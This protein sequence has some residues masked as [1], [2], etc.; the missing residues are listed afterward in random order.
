MWPT[1]FFIVYSHGLDLA[2]HWCQL[3]RVPH[4]IMCYTTF[5]LQ[6]TSDLF[7]ITDAMSRLRVFRE[8]ILQEIKLSIVFPISQWMSFHRHHE[9]SNL[10]PKYQ[11]GYVYAIE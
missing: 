9:I 1:L 10:H 7:A 11:Y 4:D 5:P 3:K 8:F 6:L 2:I